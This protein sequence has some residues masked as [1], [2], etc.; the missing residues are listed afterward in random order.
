MEETLPQLKMSKA[1]MGR[2]PL[3]FFPSVHL[4]I[5]CT[6]FPLAKPRHT[7]SGMSLENTYFRVCSP[8]EQSR[9]EAGF[10]LRANKPRIGVSV[11]L[12]LTVV[13]SVSAE[14]RDT[15]L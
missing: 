8:V 12:N 1:K 2:N 3:A 5:Y 7:P 4:P 15:E 9:G 13:P 11:S 14:R 6:Y 10:D